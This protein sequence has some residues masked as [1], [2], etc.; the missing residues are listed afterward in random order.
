MA[1]AP[2]CRSGLVLLGVLLWG[3]WTV[4]GNSSQGMSWEDAALFALSLL[5]IYA[6][7]IALIAGVAHLFGYRE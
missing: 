2:G 5:P 1:M 4:K 7:L 3:G 6:A